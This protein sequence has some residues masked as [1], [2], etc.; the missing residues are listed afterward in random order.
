MRKPKQPNGCYIADEGDGLLL[1]VQIGETKAGVVNPPWVKQRMTANG[2]DTVTEWAEKL[3]R[4]LG[5]GPEKQ[6]AIL[7]AYRTAEKQRKDKEHDKAM[8]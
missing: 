4:C 1:Y 8:Q 5:I 7:A 3:N 2:I 6:H